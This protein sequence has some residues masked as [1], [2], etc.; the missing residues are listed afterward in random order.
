MR[1]YLI[2]FTSVVTLV[3]IFFGG[4]GSL[5]Q[6]PKYLQVEGLVLGYFPSPADGVH[7][8]QAL[9]TQQQVQLSP[10]HRC[11]SDVEVERTGLGDFSNGVQF[12]AQDRK[13]VRNKLTGLI[14]YP[15]L[16]EDEA[17]E[18][19]LRTS[20]GLA[21]QYY[22]ENLAHEPNI[23]TV[24]KLFVPMVL[25]PKPVTV[26]KAQWTPQARQIMA[27]DGWAGVERYCGTHF[28]E[29]VG[30]EMFVIYSIRV[31]FPSEDDRRRFDRV[32]GDSSQLSPAL[33]LD[34]LYRMRQRFE[35]Y[36][37]GRRVIFDV[38]QVGGRDRDVTALRREL[39]GLNAGVEI[40]SVPGSSMT[41]T[42]V[43][44]GTERLQQC[45]A[46]AQAYMDF[47]FQRLTFTGER[48]AFTPVRFRIAPLAQML[49]NIADSLK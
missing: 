17:H 24:Q 5:A 18:M 45:Q 33:V 2:F 38:L 47:Q 25:S 11:F 20:T 23:Q 26:V 6:Q 48:P 31:E 39:Q 14:G 15:G 43:E 40:D 3:F 36:G 29:T 35:F 44:C 9:G 12:E 37:A 49:H 1:S 42:R 13:V 21:S 41:R 46:V 4:A 19:W 16:S 32:R 27:R 30:E 8:V 34:N 10:G 7:V 28:V 22:R